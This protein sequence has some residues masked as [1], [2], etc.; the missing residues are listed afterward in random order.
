MNTD[1]RIEIGED[2]DGTYRYLAKGQP[3][4]VGMIDFL[5]ENGEDVQQ[6][7]V[8]RNRSCEKL[9]QFP[10]DSELKRKTVV[11][12]NA[13]QTESVR[14]YVKGAPEELIPICSS[15]VDDA[16]TRVDFEKED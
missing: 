15:T 8:K 12:N 6:F 2:E 16:L 7:F 13:T 14:V 11:R 4:E 1:A 10:F 9:M 5:I 3:I